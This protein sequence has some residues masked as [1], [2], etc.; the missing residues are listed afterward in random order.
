MSKLSPQEQS[1]RIEILEQRNEEFER[2]NLGTDDLA[3][4]KISVYPNPTDNLLN[5][6]S[7]GAGIDGVVI[8][9]LRGRKV[10][11]VS[12]NGERSYAVDMS[13]LGSAMY[14]ITISTENG[15]ITKR[16]IKQ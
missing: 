4:E 11:E 12:L 7:P 16:V 1:V 13:A 5:I 9:D 8:Y 14:Y 2:E 15:S 3:L 10:E 6:L